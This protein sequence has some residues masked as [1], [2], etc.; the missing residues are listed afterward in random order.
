MEIIMGLCD[1]VV[2]LNFGKKLADGLPREVAADKAVIEA[3]L[4]EEISFA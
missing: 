4:G 2:A 3:Y 1:R